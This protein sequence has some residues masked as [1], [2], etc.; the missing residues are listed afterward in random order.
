MAVGSIKKGT[1]VLFFAALLMIVGGIVMIWK[2]AKMG[3]SQLPVKSS[4]QNAMVT[5]ENIGADPTKGTPNVKK[6]YNV[7]PA[8]PGATS[9][10]SIR[11]ISFSSPGTNADSRKILETHVNL[12]QNNK[13]ISGKNDRIEAL[14][15]NAK[16]P[17][18]EPLE[19][20]NEIEFHNYNE[21]NAL[22]NQCYQIVGFQQ[23]PQIQYAQ[24]PI[25]NSQLQKSYYSELIYQWCYD[26]ESYMGVSYIFSYLPR[27]ECTF[28]D[29][30]NFISDCN[31]LRDI[32]ISFEE[33]YSHF[34]NDIIKSVETL[35]KRFSLIV[36]ELNDIWKSLGTQFQ[37]EFL[38]NFSRPMPSDK[39]LTNLKDYRPSQTV[40]IFKQ[41]VL[42]FQSLKDEY[43][44]AN[45]N[46][47]N[48]RN[49]F[50]KTFGDF[51]C[52]WE[53]LVHK[54]CFI[55]SNFENLIAKKLCFVNSY[56]EKFT[57]FYQN[58]QSSCNNY[59]SSLNSLFQ[60][61]ENLQNSIRY[62]N[63]N[64]PTQTSE[65]T[66]VAPAYQ[67][68]QY[69][70]T[71]SGFPNQQFTH[72]LEAITRWL[73]IIKDL[74]QG[75]NCSSQNALQ[76][77]CDEVNNVITNSPTIKIIHQEL[78]QKIQDLN[79]NLIKSLELLNE[80]HYLVGDLKKAEAGLKTSLDADEKIVNSLLNSKKEIESKYIENWERFTD[81]F[82]PKSLTSQNEALDTKCKE[83]EEKLDPIKQNS[84]FET[85][86]EA[87]HKSYLMFELAV[88]FV[89]SLGKPIEYCFLDEVNQLLSLMHPKLD[90]LIY[91]R[92]YVAKKIKIMEND[93]LE[94]RTL[95]LMV[96]EK[97]TKIY[98]NMALISEAIKQNQK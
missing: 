30:T 53:S 37:S 50:V 9:K 55:E 70:S 80:S 65:I 29:N 13:Q 32:L 49:I 33:Q 4:Q 61:I 75:I 73:G 98:E 27:I 23:S 51:R 89:L 47:I 6:S 66:N 11:E 16:F 3:T 18:F 58:F 81:K 91:L 42:E 39:E 83:L 90:Q 94:T 41:K 10:Q 7:K 12:D 20:K 95:I 22:L 84:N 36:N 82:S 71:N 68:P 74:F 72:L 21:Q 92:A 57:D 25:Y 14:R 26:I 19:M 62:N 48:V 69:M 96:T 8:K 44:K 1:I 40:Q 87:L 76:V 52:I 2:G 28:L 79:T 86:F 64:A 85:E 88:Q 97:V 59:N 15:E 56:L 45:T 54:G 93:L 5:G 35:E 31:L 77:D 60:T 34:C 38:L 67:N 43:N 24:Y 17:A 63:F 46:R 78:E